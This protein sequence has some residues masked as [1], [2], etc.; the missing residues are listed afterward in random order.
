MAKIDPI[1][2]LRHAGQ[3]QAFVYIHTTHAPCQFNVKM[4]AKYNCSTRVYNPL[5]L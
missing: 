4:T 1:A 3:N 2:S 5:Y